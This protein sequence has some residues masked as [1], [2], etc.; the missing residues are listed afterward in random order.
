MT[1]PAA[2]FVELLVNYGDVPNVNDVFVDLAS[3]T[4]V[5]IDIPSLIDAKLH[6]P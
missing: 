4:Y 6:E 2:E 5:M 3:I 1:A